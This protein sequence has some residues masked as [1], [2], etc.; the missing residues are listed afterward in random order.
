MSIWRKGNENAEFLVKIIR[1]DAVLKIN[2][3]AELPE[4]VLH[5]DSYKD[6]S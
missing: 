6:V 4:T 3:K 2:I 1:S 5:Q